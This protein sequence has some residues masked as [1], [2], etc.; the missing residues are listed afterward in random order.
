M[1]EPVEGGSEHPRT[2]PRFSVIDSSACADGC[3]AVT[4]QSASRIGRRLPAGRDHE[5]RET[6]RYR[7]G[8]DIPDG[9]VVG[10]SRWSSPRMPH[11]TAS[12]AAWKRPPAP[13]SLTTAPLLRSPRGNSS[14]VRP[15]PAASQPIRPLNR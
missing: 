4:A 3:L 5:R 13:A 15:L 12:S 1:P 14:L 7:Q 6:T 9:C 10:G 11:A 2:K 8:P